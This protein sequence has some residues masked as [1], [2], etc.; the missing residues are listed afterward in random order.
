MVPFQIDHHN[1]CL[2]T[3][4]L[5]AG[6]AIPCSGVWQKSW[7]GD[8]Q[9]TATT[10]EPITGRLDI[11]KPVDYNYSSIINAVCANNDVPS[12]YICIII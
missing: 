5:K 12:M 2:Y 9:G 8:S 10:V 1:L 3:R 4:G 7:G 6:D 11:H